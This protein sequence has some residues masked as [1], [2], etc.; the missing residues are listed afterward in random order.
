MNHLITGYGE[1]GKAVAQIIGEKTIDIIDEGHTAPGPNRRVDIL[2]VCFPY[3]D[4]FVDEVNSYVDTYKPRH[5]IIYST[6]AIG[7]TVQIP[8]AVHSPVEGKHPDLATSMRLM[9]RWVGA[10]DK[11]EAAFFEG[12]FAGKGIRPHVVMDSNFTEFLKL[13]STSKYG[14]NLMWTDYEEGVAADLGMPFELIND[15]DRDYNQL[16]RTMGLDQYQRYIL[17]PPNGKIGGHCVVPNAKI[18]GEQYPD[19]MLKRLGEME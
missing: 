6:V 11:E 4:K 16:Y 7:T 5:T 14:I 10:N 1:I 15:F 9:S 17:T 8:G 12:F 13:R 3:D 18:L 19:D 2:H